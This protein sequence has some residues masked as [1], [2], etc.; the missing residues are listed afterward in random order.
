MAHSLL[1]LWNAA[2]AERKHRELTKIR[3][4]LKNGELK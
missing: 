2:I 4:M 1:E 3:E